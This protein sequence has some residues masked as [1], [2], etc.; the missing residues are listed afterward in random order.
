[1]ALVSG[2]LAP[3]E[4]HIP[5]GAALLARQYRVEYIVMD[6]LCALGL[7]QGFLLA[8][9]VATSSLSPWLR[10]GG[11]FAGTVYLEVLL[12]L[13]L[14]GELLGCVTVTT[15]TTSA[16]LIVL[17]LNGVRF[18]RGSDRFQSE[19]T[20]AGG[21]KFSIR[22]MMLFTLVVALLSAG[23]RFLRSA[24]W[25]VL[26]LA[27]IWGLCSVVVGIVALWAVLGGARPLRR[28]ATV[29]AV[30]LTLGV[31]FIIAVPSA[32]W[33]D[34]ILIMLLYPALLLGSLLVIRLCGYCFV[35]CAAKPPG[36]PSSKTHD[37]D[38]LQ[39]GPTAAEV[40]PA[41]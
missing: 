28:C 8:L 14:Q 19:R 15:L 9:W 33:G 17:R 12:T 41:G 7:C 26:V 39:I 13:G 16:S 21:L 4:V 20:D 25:D 2:V 24:S 27:C 35:R 1:L 31:L 37:G 29:F 34:L 36:P 5:F 11:L 18:V 38:A 30:S 40:E 6:P 23:V 22:G 3:F 10:M 32:S